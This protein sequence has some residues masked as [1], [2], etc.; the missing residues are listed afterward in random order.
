MFHNHYQELSKADKKI[1][2]ELIQ[3]GLDKEFE[4]GLAKVESA[5]QKW[6]SDKTDN[7]EA[8]RTVYKQIT[9]FD[10]HI[11]RRYDALRGSMYV[12]TLGIQLRDGL[13]TAEDIAP[14]SDGAKALIRQFAELL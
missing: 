5:I 8:Y 2:Q 1:I 3:K 9:D 14:L 7:G 12:P 10:K 11:A 6:R 13:L 4:T